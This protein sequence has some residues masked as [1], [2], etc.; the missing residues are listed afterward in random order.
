MWTWVAAYG[1]EVG[2]FSER[3]V[4]L[5]IST[6]PFQPYSSIFLLHIAFLLGTQQIT[7]A[8]GQPSL[9]CKDHRI[10]FSGA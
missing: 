10:T 5:Q 6:D 4:E 8:T 2:P 3:E 9:F 1:F 7:L